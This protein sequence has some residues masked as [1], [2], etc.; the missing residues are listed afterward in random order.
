MARP[1]IASK[2]DDF[3]FELPAPGKLI[4]FGEHA[5]VYGHPGIAAPIDIGMR[6]RVSRDPAG[7]RLIRPRFNQYFGEAE[8]ESSFDLFSRAVKQGL[9]IYN[10]EKEPIA[11]EVESEL[12]VGMGL[13]SSAA[14]SAGVC[15]ALRRCAGLESGD[16]E[17]T[18]F[19]DVQQLES[20]FHGNPSGMD[21]AT[22]LADGVLWFRKGPPREIIPLRIPTPPSGL[23]CIV[24][25]GASTLQ[26]VRMVRQNLAVDER[27]V[28]GL[29]EEIGRIVEEAS[30]LLG[31]GNLVETGE[32]MNR[33]HQL[34]AALGVSTPK[35]DRATVLLRRQDGVLGAKL[36]GSGGGG[37]V[38]ALTS[39]E[40]QHRLPGDLA[41]E[42]PLVI[43]FTAMHGEDSDRS[44]PAVA[45]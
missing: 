40:A 9:S 20:I 7:P 42:F 23:I 27:R 11:I 19:D 16:G 17:N 24:E 26:Q 2:Q 5:T 14:F 1:V 25:P 37:A 21:A 38:I 28:R 32:L 10:L 15:K 18:L 34:L 43:P 39:A 44:G 29:L 36:T 31:S 35:L 12:P 4:L 45:P 30:G 8:P 13:G 6:I 3:P 22:V 41:G 33:N